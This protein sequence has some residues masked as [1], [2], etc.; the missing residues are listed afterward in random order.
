MDEKTFV[1]ICDLIFKEAHGREMDSKS[2]SDYQEMCLIAEDI[3]Y[4]I[5]NAKS[6]G[7]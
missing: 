1:M 2:F 7:V 5:E 4:T 3:R 6:R